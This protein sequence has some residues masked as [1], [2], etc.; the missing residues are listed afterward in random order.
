[1]FG[2]L[3]VRRKVLS[4]L[5]E[6][7]VG[8]G[9]IGE[10]ELRA[11]L[12]RQK[13]TGEFLGE[14][15]VATGAVVP[16]QLRIYLEEATG[17]KFVDLSEV[18][19]NGDV[20]RMLPEQVALARRALPF[21]DA[22]K[23]IH[24]A[25]AD[26]L[27]VGAA[28]HV[29]SI[30]GKGVVTYVALAPDIADATKRVFDVRHKAA[31]VLDEITTDSTFVESGVPDTQAEEAPIVRLINSI[32]EGAF[33]AGA[34]DIHLEPHEYNVRVRY[35]V[36]GLLY[37]QMTIPSGHLNSLVS[38]LKI[39]ARLDIAEKRRPQDGR[40][41]VKDQEG[42]E[43]DVRLSIVP[44]VHGEKACMRLLEKKSSLASMD[45]LGLH[46]TQRSMFDKFLKRQHGLIL[47][48]GPTGSGKSTTLYAA[49]N[50]INETTRNINTVEDPVEFK[51]EGVNQM[52]VN[53]KIGLTFAAGLRSLVRQDPDVILVGEIRDRETAEI[54][55]QA[56]LTGHLVLSSLHTNDA[57]SALVRLQ[58]MGIEPFLI[59]SSVIGILGQRLLRNVCPSCKETFVLSEDQAHA[60]GLDDNE[61]SLPLV[62]KGR[63]CRRCNNRGMRGRTAAYEIMSMDDDIRRL[64]LKG[65]SSME[66]MH[67]AVGG[68]GMMTMREAA[69]RKVMNLEVAPEEA[70]R[71]F[72]EEE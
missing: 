45:K 54:A 36:D 7:L 56:A 53:H 66:L 50:A 27:D 2:I 55:V 23:N 16:S 14:A 64:V 12:E 37:D 62:A 57:H 29:R 58:N 25:M 31:S 10:D 71:V 1:M 48:T 9:I 44:T 19:I 24:V 49:L 18:E 33:S 61:T 20:A 3:Q 15:L 11:A 38:R 35:R 47:V 8:D 60:M 17:F 22:G 6:R 46:A 4:R 39:I 21:R 67:H 70:V 68:G 5:G 43:Y 59:S 51:L 26:P 41:T 30:L 40:F 65:S 13:L 72:A 32:V 63:G 52:Q 34:S 42:R 69:I 28:D